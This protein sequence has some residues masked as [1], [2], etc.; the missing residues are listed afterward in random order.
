M[1]RPAEKLG[2]R[3]EVGGY[4]RGIPVH[5]GRFE[6]APAVEDKSDERYA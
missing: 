5:A 2:R 4:A 6:C 3:H 1:P